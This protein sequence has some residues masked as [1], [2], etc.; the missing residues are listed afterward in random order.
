M[1]MRLLLRALRPILYGLELWIQQGRLED[2]LDELM[3]C[4]GD[5]PSSCMPS[6]ATHVL[7][8]DKET[9]R[10]CQLKWSAPAGEGEINVDSPG[11]WQ[12]GCHL[13]RDQS[14]SLLCP[15]FLKAA[16][17]DILLAGKASLLLESKPRCASHRLLLCTKSVYVHIGAT[18][19]NG[20]QTTCPW[21]FLAANLKHV[22]AGMGGMFA[23]QSMMAQPCVQTC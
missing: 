4:K 7:V 18:R 19:M 15:Q 5:A 11:F 17:E 8:R 22:R 20:R 16:A 1:V 12:S 13:R 2:H 14:G 10:S 3:V 9:D 6:A 23:L 21:Q